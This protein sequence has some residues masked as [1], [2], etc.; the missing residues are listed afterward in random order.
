MKPKLSSLRWYPA[1]GITLAL[2]TG[3]SSAESAESS[4]DD[5]ARSVAEF[6]ESAAALVPAEI[7]E[8]GALQVATTIGMAPL[9]YPDEETGEL[10]GFNV[11]IMKQVGEVLGLEIEM[12][13]VSLEQI[14]P[15]I[16]AGRY[17]LTASNMAITEERQKV[18]D[19][20]EYYF[21][22][23]SLATPAG[24]P[25]GLAADKLCGKSV[26]VS[27]GSFQ[28]TQTLPAI[29]ETCTA[30]GS[31]AIN[32]QEFPDQQKAVLAMNSGRIDAVAADSA[33]LLYAADLNKQV[34]VVEKIT[35]G[36]VLGIGMAEG[37]TLAEAIQAAVNDLIET[38][39][40]QETLEKY[41]IAD[42]GIEHSEIKK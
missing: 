38:G 14:I 26:G 35:A 37:S 36:S 6:N 23:S 5:D 39:K 40:Y 21:G 1:I 20:V 3:C 9:G 28:Q 11:D 18:L 4:V 33:I 25:E 15:G 41:G 10:A 8:A 7:A 30:A 29:S 16:Q 13:G 24:N 27:I 31:A 34:E 42:L 17:D 12:H 22:S 32:M 2:L 19:F